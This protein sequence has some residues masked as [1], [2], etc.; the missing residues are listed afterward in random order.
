[1]T[2]PTFDDLRQGRNVTIGPT[3]RALAAALLGLSATLAAQAAPESDR[4]KA[5][6]HCEKAVG[7]TIE[8]V[9]AGAHEIQFVGAQRVVSTTDDD[10]LAVRGEGHYRPRNAS[11]PM[12][13]TYSC[14]FN[15]KTGGTSGVIFKDNAAAAHEASGSANWQPDLSR[16]SPDVCEAGV[17]ALLKDKHPRVDHIV[18]DA[19]TRQLKPAP[20]QQHLALEGQGTLQRAPGM[21]PNGFHYRCEFDSA[22][23]KLLSAQ[24]SD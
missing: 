13:F 9:R 19:G 14:A 4:E 7:E 22:S 15:P 3:P 2:I 10:Q 8:A 1:V 21:K 24:G 17:A 23:G 6:E 18:F 5:A 11:A 12:P 20:G 16:V